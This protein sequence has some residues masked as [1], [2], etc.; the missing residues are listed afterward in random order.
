VLLY[1]DD[2][3]RLRDGLFAGIAEKREPFTDPA[4]VQMRD[5]LN[6][7]I[8]FAER[9]HAIP[10][11]LIFALRGKSLPLHLP[12]PKSQEP[13]NEA[14]LQEAERQIAHRFTQYLFLET[15]SGQIVGLF[16]VIRAMILR[17]PGAHRA[18]H[19][20]RLMEILKAAAEAEGKRVRTAGF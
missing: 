2:L 9:F 16:L 4:Y 13:E 7:S 1:R 3:F 10:L 20:T 18:V 14:L 15:I 5:I 6:G 8:R 19:D 12:R 17:R 11:V